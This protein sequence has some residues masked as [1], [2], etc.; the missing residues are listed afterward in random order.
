MGG[1]KSDK[2]V[3][4]SQQRQR[5]RRD[6][7]SGDGSSGTSKAVA[8]HDKNTEDA[9]KSLLRTSPN[10]RKR[11]CFVGAG[12]AECFFFSSRPPI[13]LSKDSSLQTVVKVL[14]FHQIFTT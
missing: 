7:C 11:W 3:G 5:R 10:Q 1:T 13:G 14:P 4:L 6:H 8:N 12:L 2:G 9:T